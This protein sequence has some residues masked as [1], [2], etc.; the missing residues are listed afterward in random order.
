MTSRQSALLERSK[1]FINNSLGAFK[2]GSEIDL[3]ASDLRELVNI[4]DDVVGTIT[5]TE[6]IDNIFTNFCVGK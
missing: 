3:L 1:V 2:S 4:L 6:V 5:N